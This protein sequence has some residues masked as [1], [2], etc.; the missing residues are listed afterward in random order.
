[1]ANG[2]IAT[3]PKTNNLVCLKMMCY[4]EWDEMMMVQVT[5]LELR[6][7]TM[8]TLGEVENGGHWGGH[9]RKTK[10]GLKV[11]WQRNNNQNNNKQ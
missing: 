8:E 4:S 11:E 1:M 7:V 2:L 6:I 10:K 3:P 9:W 5:V